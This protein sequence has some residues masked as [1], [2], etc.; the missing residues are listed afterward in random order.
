MGTLKECPRKYYYTIINGY[1][2]RAESVHLKFGLIY[3]AALER[4]D[5]AK[6][7]GASHEQAFLVAVR[8]A[9]T[10]TWDKA[11]KK[12]WFSGDPNKNRLTLVRTIVWYL[13]Q[14][15][16]DPAE[17]VI[18][19]NGKPAVELSFRF[20]TD[21]HS[22]H[23][24]PFLICGHLDRVATFAGDRYVFDRKTTKWQL[25]EKFFAQFNP[26][27]QMSTY[28][29]A[30]KVVY[31][32][33]IKGVMIDGAQILVESSRFHREPV[34]RTDAQLDEWYQELGM[35]LTYATEYAEAGYWPMNDKSCGNYGGCPFIPICSKDPSVR[36]R[37]LNDTTKFDRRIWDPLIARGDV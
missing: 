22:P 33:P 12:P 23:G 18:L 27:N 21:Y 4:Y 15:A 9:M 36:L 20:N 6:A 28:T 11:L 1:I 8:Y 37:W 19:A 31:S 32:L 26:N 7:G 25:N 14:F 2:P 34:L 30:G 17:T 35:Y 16:D 3:H 29:F 13:E 10:A 5:H 24:E